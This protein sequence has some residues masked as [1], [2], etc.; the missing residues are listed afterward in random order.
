VSQTLQGIW[1]DGS[2]DPHFHGRNSIA[3]G[4]GRLE[5]ILPLAAVEHESIVLIGNTNPP[6]LTATE[7]SQY[8]SEAYRHLPGGVFPRLYA[9]PLLTDRTTP[10][11][12]YEMRQCRR[13]AFIKGFLSGVS[14]DGGHNVS[15]VRALQATLIA[16]HDNAIDAPPLPVHWHMERKFD[17]HGSVIEM[18][19]REW[20][21]IENDLALVLEIDPEGSH[22]V[23]HVSDARTIDRLRCYREKGFTV[24]AEIASHYLV[25]CHEDL[26]E[27]QGGGTAFNAHDLCWPIYKSRAS[28]LAL[29]RAALTGAAE[30]WAFFGSDCA[31]HK[32]DPTR[33]SDSKITQRGVVCGGTAILPAV[34]KSIVIDLFVRNGEA[35]SL[36]AFLSG[37]ARRAMGLPPADT[38]ALYVREERTIPESLNRKGV[39]IRPFMA[40]ET[41][42]WVRKE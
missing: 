5:I 11:M 12:I 28:Q 8:I 18:R 17:A 13:V 21:A 39:H 22:T 37:N 16:C 10:T 7:A 34:S 1:L 15:N 20:Y 38:N 19:E 25:R 14:N 41:Y 32:N 2:V 4:D 24:Y 31:C 3:E 23:K 30:G 27:G 29:T 33:E 35:L 42:H 6:L 26:Y 36:D 40:G 9:A